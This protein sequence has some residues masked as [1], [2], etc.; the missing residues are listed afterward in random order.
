MVLALLSFFS[1]RRRHTRYY[2]RARARD[3]YEPTTWSAYGNSP[4]GYWTFS[5]LP[6][7]NTPPTIAI[8][9][10]VGGEVWQPHESRT[11]TWTASD[12]EDPPSSLV[13][14]I[15]YTSSAGGGLICGPE[16]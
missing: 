12:R 15:N 6:P 3:D 13:V 1:S 2:W 9:S 16:A 7:P 4:P 10:P 5:T 14:F 11:V 8:I